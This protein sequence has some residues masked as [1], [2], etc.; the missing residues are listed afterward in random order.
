MM[1]SICFVELFRKQRARC[2][3]VLQFKV[4]VER[5]FPWWAGREAYERAA[6]GGARGKLLLHMAAPEPPAPPA[7]TAP[8]APPHS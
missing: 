8:P 2:G 4:A 5:V 6:A 7:P 1:M 3:V